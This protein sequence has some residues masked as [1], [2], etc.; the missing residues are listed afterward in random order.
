MILCFR[1]G[2]DTY[3]Y[4]RINYNAWD[5]CPVDKMGVYFQRQAYAE[6]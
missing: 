2:K 3:L 6:L 5:L 1:G 4:K